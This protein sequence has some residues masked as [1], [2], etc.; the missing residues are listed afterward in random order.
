MISKPVLI[1]P[2]FEKPFFVH[3]DASST[4]QERY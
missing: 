2:N 1:Q 4:E 3:T